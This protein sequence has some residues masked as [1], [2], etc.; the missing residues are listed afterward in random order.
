MEIT[1][2][3]RR[4]WSTMAWRTISLASLASVAIGSLL[5]A[6]C[7]KHPVSFESE[8]PRGDILSRPGKPGLVIAAPHGTSDPNTA[9]I[10][11]EIARRTGFGLVVATGFTL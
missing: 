2:S 11:A 9:D 6:G 8:P 3:L 1:R 4:C 7:A 5:L 10:A